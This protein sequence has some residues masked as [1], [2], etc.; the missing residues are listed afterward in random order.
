MH[1]RYSGIKGK[2]K[3]DS[4]FKCETCANQQTDITEDCPG[5]ELNG[6]PFE[7]VENVRPE[8]RISAELRTRLKLKNMRECLQ[9]KTARKNGREYLE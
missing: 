2:L 3:Y 8:D 6:E 7:T 5:I 1:E 9:N 4:K